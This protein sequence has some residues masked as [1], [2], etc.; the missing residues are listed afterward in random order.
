[1]SDASIIRQLLAANEID[2]L[3]LTRAP[4]VTAGGRQ[5]LPI[6][7]NPFQLVSRVGCAHRIGCRSHYLKST[8][9][10]SLRP[11]LKP[12]TQA[13]HSGAERR[14]PA[15]GQPAAV[16]RVPPLGPPGQQPA[17]PGTG[18]LPQSGTTR[19]NPMTRGC[20]CANATLATTTPTL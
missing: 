17:G 12:I 19:S 15:C 10:T 8:A 13:S 5:P 9:L 1:M 7:G 4:E 14:V 16:S 20:A 2:Q 11:L 18:H 6:R 3:E